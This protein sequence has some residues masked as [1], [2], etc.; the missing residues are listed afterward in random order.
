MEL[1]VL[2]RSVEDKDVTSLEQH[3][4]NGPLEKHRGRYTNQMQGEVTYLAALLNE[5][6]VG[7]VL[8]K[9]N[10]TK[11]K[12]VATHI[13]NCPDLEDLFVEYDYRNNGMAKKM[14]HHCGIL[15]RQKGF[16]RLGLGV[17][18]ENE[19]AKML[20]QKLGFQDSGVGE[21]QVGGTYMAENGTTCSWTETCVYLIKLIKD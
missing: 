18:I 2:I 9:W 1:Q 19:A 3:M 8:I 12:A 11:D 15:A 17:G 14:L 13:S 5:I 10:G 16:E 6:P 20:Y 4:N 7:H 21:Y